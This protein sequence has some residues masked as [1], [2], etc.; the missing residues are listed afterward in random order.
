MSG[1]EAVRKIVETEQQAKQ[2]IEDSKVRAQE[3]LDNAKEEAQM[4]R[5]EA[6][7]KAEQQRTK[8]LDEAREK[9]EADAK[10]SDAE[11]DS[12]LAKYSELFKTKRDLAIKRAVELILGD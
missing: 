5:R 6:L 2:I 4:I 8:I 12:M 7:T 1:I 9:A 11:T 3:I 10:L